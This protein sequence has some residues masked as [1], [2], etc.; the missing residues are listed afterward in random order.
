MRSTLLSDDV[1]LLLNDVSDT[2][3]AKS[4]EEREKLIGQGKKAYE[5]IPMED[6]PTK[7]EITFYEKALEVS[8]EDT[9]VA[10]RQLA[11]SIYAR[12]GQDLVL[13]SLIRGGLATGIL[14]KRYLEKKY[15]IKVP[16]YALTL[17]GTKGIDKKALEYILEREEARNIQFVDGWTGKGAVSRTLEREV[18]DYIGLCSDLAV[19]S[20][21]ANIVKTSGTHEDI[22]VASACLNAPLSGLLSRAMPLEDSFFGAVFFEDMIEYDRTYHFIDTIERKMAYNEGKMTYE[23]CSF[24]GLSEVKEIAKDFGGIDI[25]FIKPG[26]GETIRA[27][28]RKKPDLILIKEEKDKYTGLVRELAKQNAVKVREYPL[29]KYKVCGIYMDKNSDVL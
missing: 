11:E 6:T 22:L 25:H 12:K 3:R 28:I 26:V 8:A 23:E 16:H 15:E 4:I 14:V 27:F 21:P 5:M 29:E 24:D 20:D 10:V 13:V 18:K 17:V 1:I 7:E 2:V 19:L 9:A